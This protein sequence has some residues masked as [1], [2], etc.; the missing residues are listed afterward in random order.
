VAE[1]TAAYS[2]G[3]A[4]A[5]D[6]SEPEEPSFDSLVEARLYKEYRSLERQGYTHGWTV[7]REPEP[8]LAPGIVLIPD[9]AFLRGD[10]RVFMEIAG[11]WSP[12]YRERKVAKLRALAAQE[13]HAPLI[14][15]VP[16]EAEQTFS[17]LPFPVVPYKNKVVATDLL[18]VLD[19]DYGGREERHEAAQSQLAALRDAALERGFVSDN[20]I[21]SALQAYTRTELLAMAR[22]LDGDGCRYV[23]GVGLLSDEAIDKADK[24]LTSGLAG[25]PG[26]RLDMQEASTLAAT[27]L[28][29]AQID[30]ESLL[31]LWPE[32]KVDRPSLFEAYLT[33]G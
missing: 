16:Q 21:A 1:T 18:G 31:Q 17:G 24:A 5:I 26:Q 8:V 20:E 30:L 6:G 32:L 28:G 12:T 27:A 3:S 2:V 19:R 14:L 29:V 23:A 33:P 11:F 10:T 7:Q 22:S 15:A 25:A 4:V 9:F 13:G